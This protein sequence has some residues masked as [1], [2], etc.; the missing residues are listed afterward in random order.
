MLLLLSFSSSSQALGQGSARSSGSHNALWHH[1]KKQKKKCGFNRLWS[2]SRTFARGDVSQ[3]VLQ[4]ISVK[5]RV[6]EKNSIKFISFRSIP[7]HDSFFVH[8]LPA[9]SPIAMRLPGPPRFQFCCIGPIGERGS[10]REEW[11]C[12]R[13]AGVQGVG[14]AR[15]GR[16]P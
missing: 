14:R 8:I 3:K 6:S 4:S 12:H 13:F 11:V 16:N 2:P 9:S 1:H 5:F 10:G 15:Q 7:Q